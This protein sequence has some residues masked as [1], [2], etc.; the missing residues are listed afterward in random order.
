ML[1]ILNACAN[2]GSSEHP[3]NMPS[4]ANGTTHGQM[5]SGMKSNPES[6]MH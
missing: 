2:S 4:G 6:N 5:K 3:N 1:A